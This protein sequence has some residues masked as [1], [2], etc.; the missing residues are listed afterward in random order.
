MWCT[1]HILLS[2]DRGDHFRYSY[3][4]NARSSSGIL[5]RNYILIT[6]GAER[7][8]QTARYA[9]TNQVSNIDH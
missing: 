7:V 8:K 3:D 2:G 5:T 6:I 1:I 4:L 9:G